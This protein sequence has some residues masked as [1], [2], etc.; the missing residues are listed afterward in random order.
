MKKLVIATTLTLSMISMSALSAELISKNEAQHFK[1]EHIGNINVSSTG[2][3]I[4]SPMD[5]H[6]KLSELADKKG[7]KYYVIIAAQ[8]NGPNF[9]AIAQVYK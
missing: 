5:L 7:G 9:D 3:Q 4:S 6:K 2:G 1:L 8:E